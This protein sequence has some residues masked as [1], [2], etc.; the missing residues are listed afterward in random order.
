MERDAKDNIKYIQERIAKLAADQFDDINK[1]LDSKKIGQVIDRLKKQMLDYQNIEIISAYDYEKNIQY[2]E[3]KEHLKG[4][5]Y[6]LIDENK[7]NFV[8]IIKIFSGVFTGELSFKEEEFKFNNFYLPTIIIKKE[9]KYYNM[10]FDV[11]KYDI[12]FQEKVNNKTKRYV[13]CKY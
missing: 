13:Q 3:L 5:S 12:N 2:G 11:E 8:D 4:Y 1:G 6:S 7:K 10:S 9:G